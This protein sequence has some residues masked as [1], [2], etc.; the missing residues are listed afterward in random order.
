M[1]IREYRE[2][3]EAAKKMREE[4]K[5]VGSEI[6]R[7]AKDR[8]GRRKKKHHLVYTVQIFYVTDL[9]THNVIYQ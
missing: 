1:Q 6:E 2:G 4:G 8:E 7:N 5:G 3:E 9:V